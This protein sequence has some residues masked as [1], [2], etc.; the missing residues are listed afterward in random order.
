MSQ[1]TVEASAEDSK[2][3]HD[4]VDDMGK[5]WHANDAK[6]FA[7]FFTED[8]TMVLPGDIYVKS[9]AEILDFMARGYQGPYKGTGVIGTPLSI[10][11][12][13]ENTIVMITAGG[14][15]APGE[16]T[17]APARAIRATWVCV[18]QNGEWKLSAYHNSPINLPG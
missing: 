4:L 3:L 11:F 6:A 8:G 17:V 2:A 7:E 10:R 9:R 5:V 15:L 13:D 16:T 1:F 18:R 12:I 14:V